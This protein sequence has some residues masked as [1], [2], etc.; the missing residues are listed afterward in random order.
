MRMRSLTSYLCNLRLQL[1]KLDLKFNKKTKNKKQMSN[2]EYEDTYDA[3]VRDHQEFLNRKKSKQQ[4]NGLLLNVVIGLMGLVLFIGSL[5]VGI[6]F[7]NVEFDYELSKCSGMN[8]ETS[9]YDFTHRIEI[10][11]E[12]NKDCFYIQNHPLA[13]FTI[14]YGGAILFSLLVTILTCLIF[15]FVGLLKSGPGFDYYF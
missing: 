8:S 9:S 11:A 13:R 12:Y 3:M 4:S 14:V 6:Y 5:T 1:K 7:G 15:V 2:K 10:N